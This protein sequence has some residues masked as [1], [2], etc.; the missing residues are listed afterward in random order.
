MRLHRLVIAAVAVILPPVIDRGLSAKAADPVP[1]S[2][3]KLIPADAA[4]YSTSLRLG[5]QI[6]LFIK[7]N[8][9][10]KLK[11]LPAVQ[12][13][14]QHSHEAAAKPDNPF[15]QM[16]QAMKDPANQEL[17]GLL[18]DLP[19][20]EI[21]IYGGAGWTDLLPLVMELNAAQRFAPIQALLNRGAGEPGKAQA[22][23]ILQVLNDSADKIAF[24][25][26]VIGFKLSKTSPATAQIKRLETLLIQLTANVA[27]LKGSIKR[28]QVGGPDALTFSLDGSLIPVD[29]ISWSEIEEQEGQYQKLRKRLTALTLSISL[30]VKNDYLLL[31]IGPNAGVAAKLG[32]G[33]GLATRPELAPLAKFA[34]RKPVAVSY[35]SRALAAGVATTPEDITALV[36]MAKGGLDKL[37]LTEKRRAA[38]DKDLKRLTTE[39]TATLPKPGASMSF[40]F[41]TDRGQES[42]TYRYG[43]SSASTTP[44][45]LAILDHL[46]G[47]PLIAVAGP[48]SDPTPGY[49]HLVTWLKIIY[50]HADGAAKE[51]AP[52]Q[53]YQQF[54]DGMEMVLPF[55]KK[56]D[57][58]TGNQFMPALGAGETALVLDAK[59]TSKQW[60][61]DLD[62]GGKDLPLL[63]I[64]VVRTVTDAEKLLKAFQA[65]RTLVN[66]VMAKANDFGANV[67]EGGMPKPQTKKVAAG[68]AYF[69]PLPP[70]GQ[71]DQVQPNF[72]LSDKLITFSLSIKHTDRLLTPA[73]L[74]IDG[75]LMSD[76][77]PVLSAAVVDFAGFVGAIRS[78]VEKFALPMALE[79]MPDDAPPGVGKKEIPAQVKTILDV[80]GCL[81]TYTSVTYKDG[82][83][84][85]THSELVIRDLK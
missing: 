20:Q 42:Y 47:T 58:I 16:M 13:A 66:E 85:V 65:Y 28:T 2:S 63:E 22:R 17:A 9:F 57:D 72:G 45:P 82:D 64:G 78:W 33:P 69:W 10:A 73:P 12:L 27:P 30:L 54:H 84:T 71:D 75:G 46:G 6:D 25:E 79:H 34:D 7:S 49:R 4:F 15:A 53:F 51:L 8:A 40:A 41:L 24:P 29:K 35:S 83:A 26:L 67:P 56:F 52:E 23:A 76:K 74:K 18:T 43:I 31:T 5:E 62:Q 37:P 77:R 60:Y 80:L 70:L 19:R 61:K 21:F 50:G 1:D 44:K 81:R 68:T 36:D 39:V 55:L 38:I 3:L 48:I 32:N 59:W 14:V 11:A